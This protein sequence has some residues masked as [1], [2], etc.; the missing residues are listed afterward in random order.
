[1][2]A[3]GVNAVRVFSTVF[4]RRPP[5]PAGDTPGRRA[6]VARRAHSTHRAS[7]VPAV[8]SLAVPGRLM[9]SLGAEGPGTPLASAPGRDRDD[10]GGTEESS[11]A[12]R[13]ATMGEAS[14]GRHGTADA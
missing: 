14:P 13:R 6:T 10:Q 8:I 4:K 7:S 1:M 11:P 3:F 2:I 12:G 9:R 5:V